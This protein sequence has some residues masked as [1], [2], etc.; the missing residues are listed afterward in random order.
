[1]KVRDNEYDWLLDMPRIL[2]E[3]LICMI[4]SPFFIIPSFFLNNQEIWVATIYNFLYLN[5]VRL[6]GYTAV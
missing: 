6:S 3:Y 1:M 4:I 5:F 2:L